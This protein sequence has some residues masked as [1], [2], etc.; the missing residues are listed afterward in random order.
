MCQRGKTSILEYRKLNLTVCVRG[1]GY[2]S[3]LEYWDLNLTVFLRGI[4]LYNPT[5]TG[6]SISLSVLGKS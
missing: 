6:T 3:N 4:R 5:N 1:G 2:T